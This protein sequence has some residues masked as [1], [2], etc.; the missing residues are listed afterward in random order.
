M[1]DKYIHNFKK[2]L[3]NAQALKICSMNNYLMQRCKPIYN[4]RMC[5][6]THNKKFKD[7]T[8]VRMLIYIQLG[9]TYVMLIYHFKGTAKLYKNM[10]ECA[11]YLLL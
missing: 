10:L 11:F 8:K 3:L 9:N 6:L 2:L 1:E 4:F 7:I 5:F